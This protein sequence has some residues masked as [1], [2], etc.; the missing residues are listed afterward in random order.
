MNSD[1]LHFSQNNY[2]L[3][4]QNYLIDLVMETECV[5]C[6]VA[7]ENFNIILINFRLN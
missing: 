6:E 5:Y 3:P 4:T 2:Y 1:V 7:T